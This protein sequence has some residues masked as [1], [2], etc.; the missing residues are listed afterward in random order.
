MRE[1]VA[2]EGSG[3]ETQ[4]TSRVKAAVREKKKRRKMMMG[5]KHE[6]KKGKIKGGKVKR[7]KIRGR[8]EEKKEE[9]VKCKG[10]RNEDRGE[11][12]RA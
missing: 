9:C 5:K 12:R 7:G 1:E 10:D 4:Q 3:W 8:R 11:A 2:D 6:G